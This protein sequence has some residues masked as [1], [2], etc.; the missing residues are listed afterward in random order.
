MA[1]RPQEKPSAREAEPAKEIKEVP[2][3]IQAKIDALGKALQRIMS[4]Y[5]LRDVA[6]RLVADMKAEGEYASKVLSLALDATDPVV[7]LR[8]ESIHALKELGFFTPAQWKSLERQAKEKWVDQYLKKKSV[9]R[10]PLQEGQMSR[11]DAYMKFYGGDEEAMLEEA[12]VSL[13]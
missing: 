6:L 3:A 8:H 12:I 2:P 7:A 13:S 10:Q 1:P 9:N 4:R 5:G 11:Y